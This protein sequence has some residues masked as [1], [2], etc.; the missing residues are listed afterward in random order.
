MKN[1]ETQTGASEAS[2]T[3]RTE[4]TVDRI[5]GIENLTEETNTQVKEKD[6]CKISWHKIRQKSQ[7]L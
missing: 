4:E 6:K 3:D 7:A 5:S 2:L 1:L